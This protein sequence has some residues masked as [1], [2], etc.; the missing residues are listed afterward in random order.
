MREITCVYRCNNFFCFHWPCVTTPLAVPLITA[1]RLLLIAP[2]LFY[3][4]IVFNHFLTCFS[5]SP[6]CLMSWLLF[7]FCRLGMRISF[8][9]RNMRYSECLFPNLKK[10]ELWLSFCCSHS[11]VSSRW[12]F[13]CLLNFKKNNMFLF[14]LILAI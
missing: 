5:I 7:F 13:L 9:A 2:S 6:N 4:Y 3:F 1:F 11:L 10:F 8:I 12:S 14:V